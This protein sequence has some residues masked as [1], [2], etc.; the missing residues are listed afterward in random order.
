MT[1]TT[2]VMITVALCAA[3]LTTS[4]GCGAAPARKYE[5]AVTDGRVQPLGFEVTGYPTFEELA[6]E[7]NRAHQQSEKIRNPNGSWGKG[8]GNPPRHP[9]MRITARKVL[10]YIDAYHATGEKI[11]KQRA[12]EG[13]EYIL[14]EQLLDGQFVSW[15]G[16]PPIGRI[17]GGGSLYE[18]SIPAAALIE[19]YRLLMDKRYLDAANKACDYICTVPIERG[20]HPHVLS[21]TNANYSLFASWALAANYEVT[22]NE[23]YLDRAT[24]FAWTAIYGQLP[25]GMWSD[26]HNQIIYYHGIILRG[27][28]TL[29][30]VMPED[31]PHRHKIEKAT[32]KALNHLRARQTPD[33]TMIHKPNET[34][35]RWDSTSAGAIGIVVMRLNWPVTDSV[36]LAAKGAKGSG[37]IMGIGSLLRAYKRTRK[38]GKLQKGKGT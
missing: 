25:S 19:G 24:S 22:K 8:R 6:R 23:F 18:T 4:V 36:R 29:L 11:Y 1:L 38:A 13:L 33:G 5:A 28:A 31:N 21:G 12:K 34:R 32:Y 27:L 7:F 9:M 14:Q 20:E 35:T 2:K 10:G 17:G 3:V 30:S 37:S 15:R 26:E 16:D